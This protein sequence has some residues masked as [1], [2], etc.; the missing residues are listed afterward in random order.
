[1][2]YKVSYQQ[3]WNP[4]DGTHYNQTIRLQMWRHEKTRL[5][6]RIRYRKTHPTKMVLFHEMDWKYVFPLMEGKWYMTISE[7]VLLVDLLGLKNDKR[8]KLNRNTIL[9]LELID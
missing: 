1:M 8:V 4:Y 2:I 7:F 6:K 9:K 3:D 5:N